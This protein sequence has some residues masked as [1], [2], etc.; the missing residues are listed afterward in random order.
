MKK[1]FHVSFGLI[2]CLLFMGSQAFSDGGQKADSAT[3][4]GLDA[5]VAVALEHN[6]D[7]AGA[8]QAVEASKENVEQQRANYWPQVEAMAGV[9]RWQQL[10]FL[11]SGLTMS[12]ISPVIGPTDDWQTAIQ[13][14]YKLYDGGSRSASVAAATAREQAATSTAGGVSRT[15]VLKVTEAYFRSLAAQD[16]EAVVRKRIG[17]ADAHVKLAQARY[18]TGA[19]PKVDVIRAQ[20]ASSTAKQAL[21]QARRDVEIAR[22][23]LNTAMGLSPDTATEIKIRP[24]TLQDPEKADV[25]AFLNKAETSRHEVQAAKW[26]V[27]VANEQ[28]KIARS[29]YFPKVTAS[30]AVGRRDTSFFPEENQWSMGVSVS[31]PVFTGG[32]LKH[33]L[34]HARRVTSIEES[35]L[36][37]VKLRVKQ[38]V[39]EALAGLKAAY[40]NAITAEARVTEAAEGLRLVRERYKVNAATINDVLDTEQALDE[41]EAAQ[42]SQLWGYMIAKS[43]LHW[44]IGDL[45]EV[46]TSL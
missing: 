12:G 41:A 35:N 44:A 22:G 14:K 8:Q 32:A 43:R 36:N 16:Q 45:S 42:V 38:Q 25:A 27:K 9:S 39:W 15:I 31:I 26:R 6:P 33:R 20:T 5:C 29:G 10:A 37:S 19:A 7:V 24:V 46:L 2:V 17:R 18:E 4:K 1:T 11:P 28:V 40:Q 3:G 13:M 23:G 21:A 34:S 30:A